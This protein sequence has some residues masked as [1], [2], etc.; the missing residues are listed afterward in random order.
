VTEPA[1]LAVT[2]VGAGP[3]T[4][5]LVG[6]LAGAPPIELR[7]LGRDHAVLGALEILSLSVLAGPVTASTDRALLDGADV[8]LVQ[9]R[10]GGS[11]GRIRDEQVAAELGVPA[12]ESLGLG[13]LSTLLRGARVLR[14]LADDLAAKCPDALVLVLTNPLPTSV[15]LLRGGGLQVVGACELPTVTAA[16]A[17]ALLGV[18]DLAWSYDGLSHRG[19]LHDVRLPDG[20]EALPGLVER[21]RASAG[22]IGGVGPAEVEA[23]GA[24]PLKYHGLLSGARPGTGR[25]TAVAAARDALLTQLLT[26]PQEL[27]SASA[28]RPTPWYDVMVA[29]ILTALAGGRPVARVLDLPEADGLVRERWADVDTKGVHRREAAT[30]AP[31]AAVAGLLASYEAQERAWCD[32]LDEPTP[33]LLERA[34]ALDL[35]LPEAA[36]TAVVAHLAPAVR[37]LADQPVASHWW[38][39]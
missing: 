38:A 26:H 20:R 34:V 18:D 1:P 8:V 27:P 30:T 29:P 2:V 12:D 31:P 16:R 14:G 15:H 17:A 13:G 7:L 22:T 5:A 11:A 36:A 3:F 33:A 21:L 25:A 24:I 39:T 10:P 37:A 6:A 9:L 4:A 32:L 35:V 19:F 28:A 23:L